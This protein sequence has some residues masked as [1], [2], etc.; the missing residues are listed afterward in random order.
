MKFIR[1]FLVRRRYDHAEARLERIKRDIV[2]LQ[3][4]KV[5]A[6]LAKIHALINMRKQESTK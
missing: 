6:E 1:R 4:E 5:L 2:A 3:D